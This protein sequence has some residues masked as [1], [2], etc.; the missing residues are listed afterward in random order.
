MHYQQLMDFCK[1]VRPIERAAG[2]A[3][4][5]GWG[6]LL[7][8]ALSLP[9]ALQSVVMMIFCVVLAGIGTRELTLR[10]TLLA[11]E[12]SAPRKLAI[13][14]LILGGVLSSYALFMLLIAPSESA[15]Q[16]ALDADPMLQSTP[17]LTGM[18]DDMVNLEKLAKALMYAGLIVVAVLA[19]GSTSLY[20]GLKAKKL[21]LLHQST[22]AW[23]VRVYRTMN[24]N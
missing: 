7:A 3:K 8:G 10:R 21:R 15:M 1:R 5:S 20:Y 2:Y 14:Q 11:L 13:N 16:S 17:E 24:V 19:Q 6:T 4:F 12:T 23:C 9:F 22:P 18:L